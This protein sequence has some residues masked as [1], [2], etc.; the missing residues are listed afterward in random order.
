MSTHDAASSAPED[1]PYYEDVTPGSGGLSPRAWYASSDAAQLSLNGIWRFRLSPTATA[2]DE[3]FARPGFDA[4]GWDEMAVPGHWVLQGHGAPAYTN[5]VYPFPV[6]PP[7][8]PTENPTGDHLHTFDV[9]DGW[10]EAGESVLRFEGVESC[11]KVWLNGHE[12]G[13]FKGSRLPHEFSVGRLLRSRGN[14]LAVRVHQWSSGS[15]LE[16]Q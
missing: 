1:L 9:P 6:D 5:T 14:V 4:A 8:V 16:D 15:Y 7:R 3:S 11:A 13:S 2:E 10:P 12:L